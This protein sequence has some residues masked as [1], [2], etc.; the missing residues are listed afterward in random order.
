VVGALVILHLRLLHAG[1]PVLAGIVA[2]LAFIK[3]QDVL[4]LPLVLLLSGRWKTAAACAATVATLAGA[5][6]L[7]LGWDGLR[8]LQSTFAAVLVTCDTCT[9]GTLVAH[10][11]GWAPELPVRATVGLVALTPALAGGS[12]RYERALMAG[13]LGAFLIT[14]YLHPEDLTLLFVCAWAMLS[15]GSDRLTRLC[16]LAG[17]PFVALEEFS[18]SVPLL[19][20]EVALLLVLVAAALTDRPNRLSGSD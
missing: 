10:L 20:A 8:A 14:P 3:P 18:G 4:L 17:Y 2:G 11:P 9:Q 12:R 15:A 16:L 19:V 6:A 7:A 13:V 5:V 1:H